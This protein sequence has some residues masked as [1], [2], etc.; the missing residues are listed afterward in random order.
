[1]LKE[2]AGFGV[3]NVEGLGV[4]VVL[5]VPDYTFS[6]EGVLVWLSWLAAA[7]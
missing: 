2:L 3:D 7:T 6:V 5:P 4:E 1:M